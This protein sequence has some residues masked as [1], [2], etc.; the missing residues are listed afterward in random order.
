MN[1]IDGYKD[2]AEVEQAA[3]A[4]PAPAVPLAL[5]ILCAGGCAPVLPAPICDRLIYLLRGLGGMPHEEPT[6]AQEAAVCA[7]TLAY[8][9]GADMRASAAWHGLKALHLAE[10]YMAAMRWCGRVRVSAA[11]G[12]LAVPQ[13]PRVT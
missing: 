6:P 4:L 5:A 3:L 2:L 11:S 13:A 12:T 7:W 8:A 9:E 10:H 1:M